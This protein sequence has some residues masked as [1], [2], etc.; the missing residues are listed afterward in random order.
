MAGLPHRSDDR[1]CF[2]LELDSLDS[3]AFE[4]VGLHGLIVDWIE[5]LLEQ[6]VRIRF[7]RFKIVTHIGG[8]GPPR[9]DLGG[10]DSALVCHEV[11]ILFF[12]LCNVRIKRFLGPLQ[13]LLALLSRQFFV[14]MREEVSCFACHF[15]SLWMQSVVHSFVVG[16][17]QHV[18]SVQLRVRQLVGW[19]PLD[20]I[21]D[22]V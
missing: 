4:C 19:Q 15:E 16:A 11:I 3:G 20:V 5:R 2:V 10:K 18:D 8:W 6:V 7:E 22:V 17:R 1:P 14:G 9:L 21:A 12:L 13:P